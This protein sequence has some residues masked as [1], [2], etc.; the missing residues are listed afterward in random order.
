MNHFEITLP[1]VLLII[2]V[3]LKLLIGRNWDVPTSLQ[4]FCELPTD[5]IFLALS[6]LVAYTISSDGNQLVGIFYCF[7]GII[8]AII[9]VFLTRVSLNLF[10]QGNRVWI[11]VTF[12]NL[13]IALFGIYSSIRLIILNTDPLKINDFITTVKK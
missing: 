9:N 1:I 4:A 7:C 11:L 8:F 2:N 10:T 6:F 5:T 3:L 12:L 13:S